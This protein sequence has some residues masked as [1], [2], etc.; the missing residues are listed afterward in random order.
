MKFGGRH[1]NNLLTIPNWSMGALAVW[2]RNLICFR[3][4]ILVSIF[5]IAFEP[6]IYLLAIGYGLGFFVGEVDGTPFVKFF[7]P[8]LLA[9]SGMFVSFLEGS[10]GG[11]SK[12]TTQKTYQVIL[13]APIEPA[14]IVLGEIWWATSKGFLSSTI[15]AAVGATQGLVD[16]WLVLPALIVAALLCWVSSSFGLLLTSYAKTYDWFIYAQSGFMIPMSLFCGTYFP[17]EH[18]PPFIQNLAYLLPLTHAVMATRALLTGEMP[19]IIFLNLGILFVIGFLLSN[20]AT[21]RLTK[22]IFH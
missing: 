20:W 16:T 10:Y 13:L 8:A 19:S 7:F 1:T 11:F 6:L 4:S 12:L 21:H 15:V 2:H 3:Y 5:W 22:Q 9:S 14:E 17:L 18:L